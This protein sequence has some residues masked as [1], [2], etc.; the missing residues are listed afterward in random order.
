M[1]AS[2]PELEAITSRLLAQLYELEG[3]VADVSTTSQAL[4]EE[5]LQQFMTGIGQLREQAAGCEDPVPIEM[6][7]YID[8]GGHPDAYICETFSAAMRDNQVAKGRAVA[9][10]AL[11]ESL[12]HEA[13]QE[14][15]EQ[16]ALIKR[17]QQQQREHQQQHL[18]PPAS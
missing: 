4:L 18:P 9:L 17:F 5:R 3:I 10:Q 16:A 15:P 7:R 11:H 14:L 12:L 13:E 1:A 2:R 6:L 8:G